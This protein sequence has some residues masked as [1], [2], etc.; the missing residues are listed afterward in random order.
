M[1]ALKWVIVSMSLEVE[2]VKS[3]C[4]CNNEIFLEN[5]C[6]QP[7]PPKMGVVKPSKDFWTLGDVAIFECKPSFLLV[8]SALK[9]CSGK[10]SFEHSPTCEG[11]TQKEVD[12]TVRQNFGENF[13]G[14]QFTLLRHSRSISGAF[15]TK[16][17]L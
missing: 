3:N 1:T 4:E 13:G 16:L 11:K 9:V 10:P 15:L 7:R 5:S 8:G 6:S 12:C 2:M 17:L 14:V